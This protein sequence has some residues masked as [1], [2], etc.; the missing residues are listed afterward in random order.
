MVWIW[1][2]ELAAA[3][4]AAGL[5]HGDLASWKRRPVAFALGGTASPAALARHLLGLD[6]VDDPAGYDEQAVQCT[7]GRDR[8]SDAVLAPPAATG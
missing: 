3:A 4:E 6:A 8:P 7:C 1:S 2:D 5:E